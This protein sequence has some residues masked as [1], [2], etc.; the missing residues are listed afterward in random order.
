VLILI[1]LGGLGYMLVSTGLGI[2]IGKMA[3]K[4]RK[5][6]QELFD[7]NSFNDLFKLL[8]K[9]VLIVLGLELIGA[10]ILTFIF[11]ETSS[12]GRSIYLGIFHS[13]SAFC[14]AGFSPFSNS[15]E[16]FSQSPAVLYTIASLV[17]LGGLGFFVLVDVI[18]TFRG[19]NIRLT[20][21]SKVTLWMTFGI[22]ILG[23]LAFCCSEFLPLIEKQKSLS[24]IVNNSFFQT[25]SA[26]TA[27]FNSIPSGFITTF[28]A[29]ILMIL[30]FIGAGSGSTAGGV[31]I[32]TITLVFVFVRSILKGNDS[33][34]F[35]GKN[36]D[37]DL[38][39][40]SLA[41]F[42]LMIIFVLTFIAALLWA[43]PNLDPLKVIFEAVSACCTVGLTFGITS[44][45]SNLGRVILIFAMFIGRVGA[46]TV[47]I[48]LMN[49]KFV[50]SNI[51]YPDGKLLI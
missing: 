50:Q 31:K 18:D 6:M 46:V 17:I 3:L 43:E 27:G 47:L 36:M 35:A 26:R 24:Y 21:H 8:K 34:P 4:D 14:N 25:I 22:I 39:R 9:A 49:S 19:K 32:T 20:F 28:S 10:T 12:I 42:V 51:K 11:M 37:I 7:I 44:D 13:I 16:S 2:L 15:L 30:M 23:F 40:K 5:I 45:I 29:F 41:V 1:Q 38:V 48:Y 33:Y